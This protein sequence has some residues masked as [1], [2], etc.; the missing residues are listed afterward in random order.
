MAGWVAGLRR[1]RSLRI[2]QLT[3]LSAQTLIKDIYLLMTIDVVGRALVYHERWEIPLDKG[4]FKKIP[5]IDSS[6]GES[7][8]PPFCRSGLTT[9]GAWFSR[10]N[11]KYCSMMR[12]S[13]STPAIVPAYIELRERRK[14]MK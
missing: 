4:L 9:P 13:T 10:D 8:H 1:D 6:W 14:I 7:V 3:V 2:K 5:G 12:V 11:A